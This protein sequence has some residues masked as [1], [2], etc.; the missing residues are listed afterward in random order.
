MCFFDSI[1]RLY[2]PNTQYADYLLKPQSWCHKQWENL[3]T[4]EDNDCRNFTKVISLI[5]C[6]I[7]LTIAT[8]VFYPVGMV[9]VALKASTKPTAP[10]LPATILPKHR[11]VVS[12]LI[13]NEETCQKI[14]RIVKKWQEIA[15]K[16]M[17]DVR[18]LDDHSYVT[19][20]DSYLICKSI[21]EHMENALRG[22]HKWNKIYV[23]KDEI[24]DEIQAIALVDSLPDRERISQLA[25]HPHNLRIN[26]QKEGITPIRGAGGTLI[27]HLV[28]HLPSS[29]EGIYLFPTE[30]S[31]EFYEK[32]GFQHCTPDIRPY[33]EY[34]GIDYMYLSALK[35][36]L[37]S[38]KVA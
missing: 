16:T 11:L 8:V 2:Q 28:A 10:I 20:W 17:H 36:R 14:G 9:G 22:N 7:P 26:V 21:T 19:V 37:L 4:I 38:K 23:C 34:D 24:S 3:T 18:G 25:S 32:C 1:H 29:S 33:P 12:E 31:F 13:E 35:I 5:A 30:S 27:K 6:F 15:W